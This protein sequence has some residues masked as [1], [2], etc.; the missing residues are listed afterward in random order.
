MNL[1][2]PARVG[3]G[4][5]QLVSPG[6]LG[7]MAL[8]RRPC[9]RERAATRVLG[10]RH[11]AQ[12]TLAL[13]GHGVLGGPTLDVLHAVSMVGLA[14]ASPRHRR[15]ALVSAGTAAVLALLPR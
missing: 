3:L 14:L 5:G 13:R 8:G 1:V 2:G 11:L 15:G 7:T 10:A 6:L 9:R 12:H 4:L